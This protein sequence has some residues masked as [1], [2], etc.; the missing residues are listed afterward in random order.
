MP[1]YADV[2]LPVPL[3]KV[4]CYEVPAEMVAEVKEGVRVCVPLGNS[5]LYAGIVSRVHHD[6]P[7]NVQIKP[8][9]SV[10]D[11][12]PVVNAVQLEFW[13]W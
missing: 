7:E 13:R 11:A 5:K 6:T 10:L 2:I 9:I 8:V 3:R 1:T 4:F 12:E